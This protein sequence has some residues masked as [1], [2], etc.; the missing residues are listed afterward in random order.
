MLAV[1]RVRTKAELQAFLDVPARLHGADPA[2]VAPLQPWVRQRLGAR[3]PFLKEA[4][5][6][7]YLA[8][9][10][11]EPVGTISSLR[12]PRHESG[13]SEAVGFFG[14]FECDDDIAVARALIDAAEAD[15]RAWGLGMLRGPRNLT[16]VEEIGLTIEGF[17]ARP[18]LLASHHGP[19]QAPLL[20][21]LG[22]EKHHDAL[23]YDIALYDAQGAPRPLTP[24]LAEHAANAGLPGLTI[25]NIRRRSLRADLHL[26]YEVFVEAFRDVPDNV[27]MP[28]EQFVNLAAGILLLSDPR[29]MQLAL[30]NDRPA[31]FAICVPELNEAIVAAHGHLIPTGLGHLLRAT[32]HIET[33]S[34][35]LLG[36]MPEHRSSGLH[37]RL[38]AA[39]VEGVRAAGYRRLEA[40]LID[41]RNGPMRHVVESAGKAVYKPYRVYERK[42]GPIPEPPSV[43]RLKGRRA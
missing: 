39:S 38:I 5:L 1:T 27:P 4:T 42:V 8:R 16:R 25:R 32:R 3:N 33:A 11:A 13:R 37:A 7:L 26:A 23:A 9:R 40:S 19:W 12:D 30:V 20:E 41:E 34:F 2:W 18:P 21:R 17:T 22:F 10:G 29:L 36:V 43:F 28:R 31:G 14:F 15:A 6:H 24:R 35:K